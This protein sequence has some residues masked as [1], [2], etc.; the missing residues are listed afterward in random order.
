MTQSRRET[1]GECK[2][3]GS[4]ITTPYTCPLCGRCWN[5]HW[6]ID[7]FN[8]HALEYFKEEIVRKTRMARNRMALFIKKGG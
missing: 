3:C 1:Y 8:I 4:K 2:A 5:F 7:R 6:E